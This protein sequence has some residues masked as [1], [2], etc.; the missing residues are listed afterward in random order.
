MKLGSTVYSVMIITCYC[1]YIFLEHYKVA[2][3]NFWLSKSSL[4]QQDFKSIEQLGRWTMRVE[5]LF[6]VLFIIGFIIFRYIFPE[7][8]K[9]IKLFLIL[10]VSLF[11]LILLI[12]FSFFTGSLPIGNITQPII[13]PSIVMIFMC[14][15]FLWTRKKHKL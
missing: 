11:L 6:F 2:K 8:N 7:K 14:I 4:T 12:G 1:V 5:F 10:N 9:N 15:Y 3:S 13:L